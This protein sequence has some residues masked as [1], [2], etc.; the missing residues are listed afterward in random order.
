MK[1]NFNTNELGYLYEKVNVMLA[2]K[3]EIDPDT[4]RILSR[5]RYKFTPNASYVN[6]N[7]TERE[8]VRALAQYRNAL[9]E[10]TNSFGIERDIIQSLLKKVGKR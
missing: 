7:A 4:M 3:R 2:H 8:L 10:N 5:I 6:L 1:I 9:L